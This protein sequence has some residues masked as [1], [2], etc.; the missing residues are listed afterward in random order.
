MTRERMSRPSSSVPNQCAVE[1][2]ESRVGRSMCAGSCG[3]IQ[4]VMTAKITKMTTN[5]PPTADNGLWRAARGSEMVIADK[6]RPYTAKFAKNGSQRA[7]RSSLPSR[8]FSLCALRFM[9][10]LS[11]PRID[12][13][14]QQVGEKIYCNVSYSNRQY[15]ALYKVVVAVADG[16]DGQTP[17]SWPGK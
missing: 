5:T 10:L 3:S 11:Y 7:L 8:W 12:C 4:E 17:D 13:R 9:F 6:S 2:E 14:I 15:A 1:G 16:V